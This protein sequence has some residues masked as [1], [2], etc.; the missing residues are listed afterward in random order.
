MIRTSMNQNTAFILTSHWKDG[1][2]YPLQYV[3]HSLNGPI[4]LKFDTE[5]FV[6]FA[7]ASKLEQSFKTSFDKKQVNLTSLEGLAVSA[8]YCKNANDFFSLRRELGEKGV[9]TFENDVWPADRFLM[10]RFIFGGLQI[11]GNGVKEGDT[12]VYLNPQIKPAEMTPNFLIC[13]LDIETGA[14]GSLYSIGVHYSGPVESEFV[15]MLSNENKSINENLS[16]F[17]DEKS[18]LLK[19]I[20]EFNQMNPDIIIGWHVIGFDLKFIEDKCLRLGVK[21]SLGRDQ[22]EIKIEEKKGS[23][24]FAHIYGRVVIDGPPTFRS[25]FYQFKNF[26]LETVASELLGE[27]KDIASDAGKVSE[28]ERRFR[29]DKE[30]L[31]YYNIQDCKLVTRVYKKVEMIQFLVNRVM[32]SGLLL[33]RLGISTA[34]LDFVYLPKLHRKGYV[35][36]N[37]SDLDRDEQGSG[38]MVIEPKIGVHENVAVFDFKSLYPSIIQTFSIDPLARY[39]ADINSVRTP[40]GIKF[41]QTENILPAIIESL[42]LKREKAK[43]LKDKPLN[44]AIKILMNSFYGLMGS[45]RCRFYHAD[46]PKAITESGHWLLKQTIEFFENR[47][48]EVIYGDTDSLF[49]KLGDKDEKFAKDIA[50]KANDFLKRTIKEEFSVESKLELEHEKIYSKIFFSQARGSNLGAKKRYV[51][52]HNGEL[53]FTGMEFVRS[54]WTDLAKNFQYKLF[55]YYFMGQSLETFI[56]EYVE[57]LKKEKFD[58]L[59]VITKRLSKDPKEYDKNIPPHVKAA[60]LIDHKGPYRLKEVSYKMTVNGPEPVQNNPSTIDYEY[61]IDKQIKPLADQVL[62]TMNKSFDSIA[63]GDQLAFF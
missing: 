35:A 50:F 8:L 4:I 40:V 41:S 61:Y 16:Y 37:A 29:E 59:L 33:G 58:D 48:L 53:E 38:G 19:F 34:A 26:K 36:S 17:K 6:L 27:G 15:Y 46:L 2:R 13:S 30:S 39:K 63:L 31:A 47:D 21:L 45:I 52:L 1:D 7:E 20:S 44:L 22:S 56:K 11:L 25:A 54:D 51:G 24:F 55:E 12:T 23:G 60:L 9:R 42:M 49:V 18:L 5:R 32:V 3:C 43:V 57:D 62:F 28:I 14:D 10:E